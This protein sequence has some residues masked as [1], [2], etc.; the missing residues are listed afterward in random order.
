MYRSKALSRPVAEPEVV[1]AS[2]TER[3]HAAER[4]IALISRVL[5]DLIEIPG[6]GRRVGLDPIIGLIPF[7][8]DGI[9][10]IAGA[11]LVAEASRFRLPAVVLARMVINVL[12]DM[13]IGLIPFLGDLVDLVS[14][15]NARN[16]ALF[17]RYALEPE[18]STSEHRR[19]F[20]GLGLVLL[21]VAWALWQALAWLIGLLTTP[22][23]F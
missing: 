8:G 16:L 4:R 10:A 3:F 1:G 9:S 18:A 11:Y 5:D 20:L 15:S 7:V 23:V 21:G 12:F 6:T 14:K 22:I 19:F 17:R 13:T 2:R